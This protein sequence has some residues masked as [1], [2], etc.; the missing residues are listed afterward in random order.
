VMTATL[1]VNRI[2]PPFVSARANALLP[3]TSTGE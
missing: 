1:P 3:E 2:F